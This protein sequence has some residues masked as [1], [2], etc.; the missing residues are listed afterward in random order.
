MSIKLK[1]YK[2]FINE[3]NYLKSASSMSK[4]G[5]DPK[6]D[7]DSNVLED[8]EYLQDKLGEKATNM[9]YP[10]IPIKV[11]I[12]EYNK[13]VALLIS[14]DEKNFKTIT[15]DSLPES[16]LNDIDL[17][18]IDS[19]N[20]NNIDSYDEDYE[21]YWFEYKS[22]RENNNVIKSIKSLAK[23]GMFPKE[24]I[25]K[26]VKELLNIN[27]FQTIEIYED[28]EMNIWFSPGAKL[29]EVLKETLKKDEL[30]NSYYDLTNIGFENQGNE[31]AYIISIKK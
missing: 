12:G 21:L 8:I 4:F 13:Y 2:N 26:K 10:W 28:G 24:D 19:Y 5:I 1:R 9:S 7:F 20:Y 6:V 14:E 11:L 15:I 31:H 16:R 25:I 18:I 23:F 22:F 17:N 29:E 27:R 3:N 30:L